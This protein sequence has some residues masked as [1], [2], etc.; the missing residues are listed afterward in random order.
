[1]VDLGPIENDPAWFID[2][3]SVIDDVAIGVEIDIRPWMKRNIVFLHRPGPIAVAILSSDEFNA[4]DEVDRASLTF[5]RTGDE[6][7]LAPCCPKRA[8]WRR[9]CV[10]D[11]NRDGLKD[12]VCLFLT[13]KTGFQ[14]DDTEG[15][16]KG[17]TV[18][19]VPI[20]GR[21]SVFPVVWIP[22]WFRA[23][24]GWWGWQ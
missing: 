15:I 5:G 3:V 7:S 22:A 4:P 8:F 2:D 9:T 19:G 21:D 10:R 6:P 16:L 23:H 18:G 24:A 11:V 1:L 20:E 12:L 13:R 14:R 17:R